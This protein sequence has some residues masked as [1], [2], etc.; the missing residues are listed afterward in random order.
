MMEVTDGDAEQ[1]REEKQEEAEL[2]DVVGEPDVLG[3]GDGHEEEMKMEEGGGGE[4]ER[5]EEGEEEGGEKEGEGRQ[6]EGEGEEDEEDGV[7]V[8]EEEEEE[9]DGVE[10]KEEEEEAEEVDGVVENLLQEAD[11]DCGIPVIED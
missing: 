8:K 6:E 5:G 11:D 4:E 2:T 9:E 1:K 7:E 10:A 3:N